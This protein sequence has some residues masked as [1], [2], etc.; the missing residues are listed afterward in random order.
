MSKISRQSGHCA[1]TRTRA[2]VQLQLQTSLYSSLATGFPTVHKPKQEADIGSGTAGSCSRVPFG[3]FG[4][5]TQTSN[6]RSDLEGR[7]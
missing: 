4:T 6:S 1:E 2:L 7:L 5:M 3:T